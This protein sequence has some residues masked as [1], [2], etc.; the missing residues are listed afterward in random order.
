MIQKIHKSFQSL[1]LMSLFALMSCLGGKKPSPDLSRPMKKEIIKNNCIKHEFVQGEDDGLYGWDCIEG[2]KIKIKS[3]SQGEPLPLMSASENNVVIEEGI[4]FINPVYDLDYEILKSKGDDKK[5][6]FLLDFI[7]EGEDF[8]GIPDTN[9]SLIFKTLGNYLILYT[10]SEDKNDIPYNQRTSMI[11][12]KNGSSLFYMAP[13]IGYPIEYC[14]AELNN[15]QQKTKRVRAKCGSEPSKEHTYLRIMKGQKKLFKYLS[16]QDTLPIDY[17]DGEWFFSETYINTSEG[18]EMAPTDLKLGVIL[19]QSKALALIDNSIKN[20]IVHLPVEWLDFELDN[21]AFFGERTN[22]SKNA[23]KRSHIKIAF[24][25]HPHTIEKVVISPEYFSFVY[26]YLTKEDEKIK[27]KVSLLKKSYLNMD[28]F[29]PRKWFPE[30]EDKNFNLF[31]TKPQDKLENFIKKDFDPKLVKLDTGLYTEQEKKSKTKI[32]KWHFSKNSTKEEHYRSLAQEAMS[33]YNRAFEIIAGNEPPKI[34]FHLA[35]GEEKDLGDIRYNIMNL[36]KEID[37]SRYLGFAPSHIH[38]ETGQVISSVSN[39]SIQNT[40]EKFVRFIRDYTRYEIFQKPKRKENKIHVV[41]EYIRW[42]IQK[43][44]SEL[45]K[46][47]AKKQGALS[48][49]RTELG[50]SDLIKACAVKVSRPFLLNVILH[51]MGHNVSKGHN[52]E[53]SLDKDNFYKDLDEMKKHFPKADLSDL[54]EL[55]KIN[56]NPIPKSSCVMDYINYQ[57]LPLPVLGKNDLM[58]LRYLYEDELELAGHELESPALHPMEYENLNNQTSLAGNEEL[59]KKKKIYLNCSDYLEGVKIGCSARDYGTSYKEIVENLVLNFKRKL[60]LRYAYDVKILYKEQ[61]IKT[62]EGSYKIELPSNPPS[63]MYFEKEFKLM[64]IYHQKWIQ[65]RDN[66]LRSES[67]LDLLDHHFNDEESLEI[68]KTTIHPDIIDQSF[69]KE[70]KDFYPVSALYGAAVKEALF[71]RPLHCRVES[72]NGLM[73]DIELNYLI[74]KHLEQEYGEDLYVI[75]CYSAQVLEFLSKNNLKLIEQYGIQ[76]FKPYKS[77]SFLDIPFYSFSTYS[78]NKNQDIIPLSYLYSQI[79]LFSTDEET[80][81]KSYRGMSL[82]FSQAFK[83]LDILR[84]IDKEVKR[85][86]LDINQYGNRY[87]LERNDL[88]LRYINSFIQRSENRGSQSESA[89]KRYKK[90]ISCFIKK[91]RNRRWLFFKRN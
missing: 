13:F 63:F 21:E 15:Q 87:E 85:N 53:C 56:K 79:Y 3:G 12:E 32:I 76:N 11:V 19:K 23:T 39:I 60:N 88:T 48:D 10:A 73:E 58:V 30:D 71:K 26:S 47:I 86:I 33:V 62:E 5:I 50:D 46:F 61:P 17:F 74:H 14:Q 6:P 43:E 90:D 69:S 72:E 31:Q 38:P 57:S 36:I 65:L 70:Y 16:K 4:D 49:Y 2:K 64:S 20:V 44:C 27:V 22:K 78:E 51:E 25:R 41:S 24:Q 7:E 89:K 40:E 75:D 80:G 29:Q 35:K 18:G 54:E 68:Y 34:Q 83:D 59:M 45:E 84:D 82:P 67:K 55:K 91:I 81:L 1:F 52:F 9:Y 77:L 42:K 28:Q 37:L 66:F 8:Q